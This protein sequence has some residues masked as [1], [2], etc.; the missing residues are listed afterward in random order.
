MAF[1]GGLG[2]RLNLAAVPHADDVTRDDEVLFSE[3]NS[4]FLAEVRPQDARAFEACLADVPHARIG[5]VTEE[6]RLAVTGLKANVVIS[7]DIA[8]LKA[9]WK[10]PLA[11]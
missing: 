11:W 5:A 4:R 2:A 3:S 8:R 6:G 10:K 7:A 1:A 9:A